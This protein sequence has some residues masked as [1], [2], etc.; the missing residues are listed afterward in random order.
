VIRNQ[1]EATDV[2]N[3]IRRKFQAVLLLEQPGV[4]PRP[5]LPQYP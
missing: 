2:T 4:M 5:R 1:E 3:L